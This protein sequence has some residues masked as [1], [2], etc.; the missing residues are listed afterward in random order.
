MQNN[1][2]L[3]LGGDQAP[4]MNCLPEFIKSLNQIDKDNQ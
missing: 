2:L 4:V 3:P 1:V